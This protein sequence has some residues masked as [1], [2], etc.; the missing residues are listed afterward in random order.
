MFR[1][2]RIIFAGIF[3]SSMKLRLPNT[4]VY[5]E[6]D[7]KLSFQI[8]ALPY[9]EIFPYILHVSFHLRDK[10]IIDFDH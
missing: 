2:E 10:E 6:L 7:N 8:G 4:Y 5:F 3:L 9:L 1:F